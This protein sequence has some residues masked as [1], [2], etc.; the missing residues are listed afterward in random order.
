MAPVP[1]TA[2][3][4]AATAAEDDSAMPRWMYITGL[5]IAGLIMVFLLSAI[6]AGCHACCSGCASIRREKRQRKKREAAE[7]ARNSIALRNLEQQ[8]WNSERTR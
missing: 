2:S 1:D 5:I 3:V 7:K 4:A 6:L 8:P